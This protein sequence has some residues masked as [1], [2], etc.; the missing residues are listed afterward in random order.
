MQFL[1]ETEFFD[2]LSTLFQKTVSNV[3]GNEQFIELQ[4]Q[5]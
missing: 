5:T 1:I 3:S 4:N 2:F